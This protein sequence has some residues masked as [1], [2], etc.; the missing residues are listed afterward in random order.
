MKL[1][2]LNLAYQK[3]KD[4]TLRK[5]ITAYKVGASNHRSA[6]FFGYE[7][8]LLG[9]LDDSSIYSK[10]ITKNYPIAEVE[11]ITKILITDC[12]SKFDI[13]DHYVGI[14]CPN[15]GLPNPSGSPF[16]CIADNCSAGDL[17]MFQKLYFLD[18]EKVSVY[19]NSEYLTSGAMSNLKYSITNIVN[20]A[21]KIIK[22]FDL[23]LKSKEL[24]IATG[25]ITDTFSLNENA[26]VEIRCE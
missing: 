13:V 23:P 24:F 18:F 8:I 20:E 3:Q 17:I 22:E 9:G 4:F 7:G 14:E 6:N 11:I 26:Q 10:K 25:G 5:N 12:G 16:I 21:F 19:V 15:V 1:V 2:N